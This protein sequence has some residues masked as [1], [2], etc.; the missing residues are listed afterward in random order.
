[1][2]RRAARKAGTGLRFTGRHMIDFGTGSLL[3]EAVH[4]GEPL[5]CRISSTALVEKAGATAGDERSLWAACR[6]VAPLVQRAAA[7]KRQAGERAADG[8]IFI[9]M[10][11]LD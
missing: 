9:A 4:D 7:R 1:M 5:T 2:T 3:V 6:R 11:D 10:A 8:S